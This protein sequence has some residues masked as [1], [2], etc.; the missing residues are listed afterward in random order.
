MKTGTRAGIYCRISTD[1]EDGRL[2]VERQE[3]D[4]RELCAERKWDV[5]GVYI[6]N[7]ISASS[8]ADR[9]EYRRLLDDIKRGT[10]DVVVVWEQDRLVRRP[11][12]FEEFISICDKAGT[13]LATCNGDISIRSGDLVFARIKSALAAEEARRSSQ[14]IRRAKLEQ[15]RRGEDHGGRRAFGFNED[16][17]TINQDEAAL[18]R[19]AARRVLGGETLYA[20]QQ[21]WIR[22]RL[23]TVTGRGSWRVNVIREALIRPR[24]TG[25]REHTVGR[26]KS[27]TVTFEA[28]WPAILERETWE[29]VRAILLSPSRKPN[30]PTRGYPLRGVLRCGLCGTYLTSMVREGRRSYGCRKE[31]GSGCGGVRI[32]A[33]RVESFVFAL[34]LPLADAAIVREALKTQE[35]GDVQ[36]TRQL[37]VENA[38]DET[39]I[40]ELEADYYQHKVID[41][42]TFL[43]QTRVL[44]D[45]ID[46]RDGRLAAL[47]GKSALDLSEGQAGRDWDKK[48]ADQK[49]LVVLSLVKEIRIGRHSV[50]GSNG[51]DVSRISFIWRFD[52]LE[53]GVRHFFRDR[54]TS[55]VDDWFESYKDGWGPEK[56]NPWRVGNIQS[57]SVELADGTVVYKKDFERYG[58]RHRAL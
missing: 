17:V 38:A 22:R 26:D 21:D 44:N 15:A 28:M 35:Q 14:R 33:E 42:T 6:D 3:K 20:I 4:C 34:L 47:R 7:N 5:G 10:V 46:Q 18:I 52:A 39:T 40:L 49:R 11:S 48:T 32:G 29:Q 36:E 2:G 56:K 12:E 19:E 31:Q 25:L 41:R 57:H 50:K 37:V 54:P 45:R 27:T 23:P 16:R 58:I 9:P 1:R 13:D 24:S 43:R 30:P 8:G 51:L 53:E 55:E